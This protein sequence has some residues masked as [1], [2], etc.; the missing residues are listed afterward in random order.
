MYAESLP[1][2]VSLP[3][4]VLIAQVVIL[5]VSGQTHKH[6]VKDVTDHPTAGVDN[7]TRTRILARC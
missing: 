2:A 1:C 4:F 3:S 7:N 6:K 5:L